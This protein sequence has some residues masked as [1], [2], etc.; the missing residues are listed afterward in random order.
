MNFTLITANGKVLTFFIL[1]AAKTFQ[2]AFGG[3]IITNEIVSIP[4][5]KRVIACANNQTA[6]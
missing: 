3:K 6:L 2:M 5:S 4:D 1:D